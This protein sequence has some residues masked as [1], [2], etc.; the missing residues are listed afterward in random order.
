MEL[1]ITDVLSVLSVNRGIVSREKMR[2]FRDT[3]DTNLNILDIFEI[4]YSGIEF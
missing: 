4:T 2:E 1:I 3:A